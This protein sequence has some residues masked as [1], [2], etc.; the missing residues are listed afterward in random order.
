MASAADC[1]PVMVVLAHPGTGSLCHRLT[2]RIVGTLTAAGAEA[3]LHDLYVEGFDPVLLAEEAWPQQVGDNQLATSSSSVD[4]MV[5]RHRREL[6]RSRGLVVVH[7]DWWGKPPAILTGW[8]DRVLIPVAGAGGP[9]G[10]DLQ[11]VLV[12]NTSDDGTAGDADPLG[13]VWRR[14]VGA[15]LATDELERISLA[16]VAEA[17]AEQ[18][19]QWLT[20]MERAA[21]W[22]CGGVR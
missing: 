10:V 6:E 15:R 11:R 17:S 20:A 7:P 14:G 4:P 5:V 8:L 13:V 12:V 2:D 3:T 19:A 18:H 16:G 1:S 22:V 9:D 21:H